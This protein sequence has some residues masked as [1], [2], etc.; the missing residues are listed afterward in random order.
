MTH[1]W[2]SVP[3]WHTTG[4]RSWQGKPILRTMPIWA[5]EFSPVPSTFHVLC[6]H[7]LEAS[8][9]FV[10]IFTKLYR[11]TFCVARVG[12]NGLLVCFLLPWHIVAHWVHWSLSATVQN[13][14]RDNGWNCRGNS[15]ASVV[16]RTTEDLNP[17]GHESL[18]RPF[19]CGV[20]TKFSISNAISIMN[21][22][23]PDN[24]QRE[25][26]IDSRESI[27]RKSPFFITC[28]RFTR[29]ASSLRF[30]IFSPAKCDSQ[31]R[32][33]C[34]WNYPK[35]RD[36]SVSGKG[37]RKPSLMRQKRLRLKLAR[38]NMFSL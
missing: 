13:Q 29:I 10:W 4:C 17:E 32:V 33:G 18:M 23:W 15:Q 31:E 37:D 2:G 5:W 34:A 24:W 21:L 8:T 19:R 7:K 22:R 25:A 1:N 16:G 11:F 27:R 12:G 28:G 30:A 9:L 20:P 38:T 36:L 6:K 35:L 26:R 3:S 14:L